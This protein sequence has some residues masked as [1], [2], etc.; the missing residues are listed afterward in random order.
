M[1]FYQS[2]SNRNDHQRLNYQ[3]R[4]TATKTSSLRFSKMSEKNRDRR[5]KRGK[6][7][8]SENIKRDRVR[9]REK[10]FRKI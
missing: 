7:E 6:E 9:E 2:I 5:R 10:G 1:L 3:L 8:G 4:N